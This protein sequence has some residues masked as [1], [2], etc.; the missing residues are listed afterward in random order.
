MI[1]ELA[2][3]ALLQV[4]SQARD[5]AREPSSPDSGR[6][7]NAARSAQ[8]S[9]ERFR[10]TALPRQQGSHPPCDAVVGRYCYWRET[11]RDDRPALPEAPSVIERRLALLRQ[12]DSAARVLPGD[13]WI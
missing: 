11:E 1:S 7:R 12:L 10:R 5:A 4:A 6:I 13:P 9:F 2:I 3:A 8:A